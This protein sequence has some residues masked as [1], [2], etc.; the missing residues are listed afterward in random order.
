MPNEPGGRRTIFIPNELTAGPSAA[1][2]AATSAAAP[3]A[4]RDVA[5]PS[6]TTHAAIVL[7]AKLLFG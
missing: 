7:M 4:G 1:A 3:A 6:N 5:A 2:S